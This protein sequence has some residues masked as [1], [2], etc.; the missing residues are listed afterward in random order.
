MTV[1]LTTSR[2]RRRRSGS[3]H[4]QGQECRKPLESHG[5]GKGGEAGPEGVVRSKMGGA[6]LIYEHAHSQSVT[7]AR[8]S[9]APCPVLPETYAPAGESTLAGEAADSASSTWLLRSVRAQV[10]RLGLGTEG[11]KTL[12][13]RGRPRVDGDRG[14]P[15]VP[16]KHSNLQYAYFSEHVFVWRASWRR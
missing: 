12:A 5:C 10:P 8:A 4:A 13:M 16:T 6:G 3:K 1:C 11:Q 15:G 9:A 14:R 2:K 7:P